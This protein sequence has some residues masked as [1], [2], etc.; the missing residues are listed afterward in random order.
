MR[1]GFGRGFGVGLLMV[2]G[3]AFGQTGAGNP[4]QATPN[5]LAFVS[6]TLH[7]SDPTNLSKNPG[8]SVDAS[9]AYY[10]SMSLKQLIMAAY[11]VTADQVSGPDW[12]DTQPYDIVATLP[13]GVSKDNLPAMLQSLLKVRFKLAVHTKSN[14]QRVLALVGARGGPKLQPVTPGQSD[15]M[16]MEQ[17]AELLTRLIPRA[18][19]T[20][21]ITHYINGGPY[22]TY[23]YELPEFGCTWKVVVDQT[24]LKGVYQV[25]AAYFEDD[26]GS[27]LFS[28]AV[29][30]LGLKLKG[31]TLKT[32]KM[33]VVDHAEK[34]PTAN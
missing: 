2:A 15:A 12:L 11:G 3:A 17:F 32:V 24:G 28:I 34:S 13:A 5:K 4:G 30:K 14:K 6:A 20:I 26:S 10:Y 25:P 19:V 21:P 23:K 16:T 31:S 22:T 1:D 8:V 18:C 29:Q 7:G 9:H 27:L 33:L